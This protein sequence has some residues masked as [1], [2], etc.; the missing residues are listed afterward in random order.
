MNKKSKYKIERDMQ[1]TAYSILIILGL[2]LFILNL[3]T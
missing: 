2:L 1:I 3:I